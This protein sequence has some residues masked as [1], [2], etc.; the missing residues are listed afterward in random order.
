MFMRFPTH[1]APSV[2]QSPENVAIP[3][4]HEIIK[5]EYRGLVDRTKE[6][7]VQK[8]FRVLAGLVLLQLWQP[9]A[10]GRHLRFQG[11]QCQL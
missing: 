11:P 5:L 8:R 7:Y 6:K 2:L 9:S 4:A 10:R 3:W 1:R